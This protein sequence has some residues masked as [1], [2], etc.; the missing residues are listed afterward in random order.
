MIEF[1][2]NFP[3]R[4]DGEFAAKLPDDDIGVIQ[5]VIFDDDNNVDCRIRA[6]AWKAE[7]DGT[8]TVTDRGTA[9]MLPER[10]RTVLNGLVDGDLLE[11][12]IADVIRV[13]YDALVK[14]IEIL[15]A[16]AVSFEQLHKSLEREL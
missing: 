6:R 10:F 3:A 2:E 5:I 9:I 7:P 4:G 13:M 14:H 11:N 12:E 15:T 16:P 1:I 8:R